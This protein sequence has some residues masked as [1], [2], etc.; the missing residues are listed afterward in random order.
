MKIIILFNVV[1]CWSKLPERDCACLFKYGMPY[2]IE[3]LEVLLTWIEE[4]GYELCSDVLDTCLLD[5]TF[6]KGQQNMDY[7]LLQA[8]VRIKAK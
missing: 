2:D 6:Y 4:N 1:D 3:D 5:T 8:P 7:F